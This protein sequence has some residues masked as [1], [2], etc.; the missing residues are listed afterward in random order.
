MVWL[1]FDLGVV[2]GGMGLLVLGRWMMDF[3]RARFQRS[4]IAE[5][6]AP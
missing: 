3:V 6:T 1:A 4:P 5:T 2:M